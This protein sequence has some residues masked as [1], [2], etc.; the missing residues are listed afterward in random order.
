MSKV[1]RQN[2]VQK[3]EYAIPPPDSLGSEAGPIVR[4][5]ID[6]AVKRAK[7]T[8]RDKMAEIADQRVKSARSQ[9]AKNRAQLLYSRYV[10][11]RDVLIQEAEALDAQLKVLIKGLAPVKKPR[12]SKSEAKA[13]PLKKA[14]KA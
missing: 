6:A 13:K 5:K 7:A 3:P 1:L 10:H 9:S 4:L 2:Q 14:P 12:K 11:E 8:V